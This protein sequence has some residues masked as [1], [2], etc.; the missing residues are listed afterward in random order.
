MKCPSCNEEINDD[1]NFCKFCG[2]NLNVIEDLPSEKMFCHNCGKL[3]DNN[4]EYCTFCGVKVEPI[5]L[6]KPISILLSEANEQLMHEN[7]DESSNLFYKVYEKD[8]Y[9]EDALQGLVKSFH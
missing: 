1:S 3:I 8:N 5:I 4:S 9:N 2:F 7:F 6:E